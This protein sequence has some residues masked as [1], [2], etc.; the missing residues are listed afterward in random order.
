MALVDAAT[1]FEKERNKNDLMLILE[2]YISKALLPWTRTF[3][4]DFFAQVGRL[5]RWP[6]MRKE[7]GRLMGPRYVGKFVKTVIYEQLPEG[8]LEELE[9]KNPTSEKGYRRHKHFQF[10]TAE[11]G[12]PHLS[13]QLAAVM[14]LMRA[15]EDKDDFW[16]LFRRAFPDKKQSNKAL[17]VTPQM[18]LP[19]PGFEV[20]DA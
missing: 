20:G 16:R 3:P 9:R 17:V 6:E 15:A 14:G 19:F 11:I 13:H 5:H 2:A 10:L 7:N 8:V 18:T 4:P 12:N 1:G